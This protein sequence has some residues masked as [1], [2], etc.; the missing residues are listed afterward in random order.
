MVN[1]CSATLRSTVTDAAGDDTGIRD[2]DGFGDAV[3]D[4]TVAG[5]GEAAFG[6]TVAGLADGC[7]LL[8]ATFAAVFVFPV[9]DDD[10]DAESNVVV[11]TELIKLLVC[12]RCMRTA[13]VLAETDGRVGRDE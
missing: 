12:R 1:L 2:T 8:D 5:L 13:D 9:I 6:V 7:D 11:A 4:I 3:F 10:C